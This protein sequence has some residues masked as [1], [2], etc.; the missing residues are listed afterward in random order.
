MMDDETWLMA[1][2]AVKK[3][4]N[5][6]TSQRPNEPSRKETIMAL[7]VAKV[8]AEYP[9]IAYALIDEGF[10]FGMQDGAQNELERILAVQAQTMPGYEALVTELVADSKTTG[11]EAAVKVLAAE[12]QIRVNAKTDLD[13]DG[14]DPQADNKALT[15]EE[16][17]Q[18]EW[19]QDGKLRDEFSGDFKAYL[20]Y[21]KNEG[22][23][24]SIM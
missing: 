8:K 4:V 13:A 23:V 18:A 24:W 21:R 14:N 3:L 15:I 1:E 7:T 19:D 5:V 16:R 6:P 9:N 17:A 20:A 11:P 10:T 12:K 2:E 22:N